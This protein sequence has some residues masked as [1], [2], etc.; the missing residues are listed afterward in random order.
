M[1]FYKLLFTATAFLYLHFS[2][3]RESI[4]PKVNVATPYA[5]ITIINNSTI[6][7]FLEVH[8]KNYGTIAPKA[9]EQFKIPLTA[10]YI[11]ENNIN[12]SSISLINPTEKANNIGISLTQ[13]KENEQT[14]LRAVRSILKENGLNRDIIQEGVINMLGIKHLF[15][16]E[17]FGQGAIL[18]AK[19]KFTIEP[20]DIP[21]EPEKF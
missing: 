16:I 2:F 7:I 3:C 20:S 4:K 11:D 1:K 6:N 9:K 14:R 8:K 21:R 5:L 18:D 15:V 12:L 19:I 13:D 10:T 17:V